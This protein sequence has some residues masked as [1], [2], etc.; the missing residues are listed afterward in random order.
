M[1]QEFSMYGCQVFA[2]SCIIVY[3]YIYML[4]PM[5]CGWH[6]HNTC[7]IQEGISFHT[8]LLIVARA[9]CSVYTDMC[10]WYHNPLAESQKCT[11]IQSEWSRSSL[12]TLGHD[13]LTGGSRG[14]SSTTSAPVGF[15]YGS[16]TPFMWM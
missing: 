10:G 12:V 3:Q 1:M 2:L 16:C 4:R 6:A 15:L 13:W 7:S 11:Q 8:P 14:H 9:L 5:M